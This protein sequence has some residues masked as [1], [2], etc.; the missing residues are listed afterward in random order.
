[1]RTSPED[2]QEL[3]ADEREREMYVGESHFAKL[4]IFP[5]IYATCISGL[6]QPTSSVTVAKGKWW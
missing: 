1:M 6:L 2:L 3:L 5:F 4:K